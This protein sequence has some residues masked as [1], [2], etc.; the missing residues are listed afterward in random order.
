MGFLTCAI[1][2]AQDCII[3]GRPFGTTNIFGVNSHLVDPPICRLAPKFCS[4]GTERFE[5]PA[6]CWET[7]IYRF[8][9]QISE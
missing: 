7:R 6:A 5:R 4:L 2:V 3:T 9:R 1:D 8:S